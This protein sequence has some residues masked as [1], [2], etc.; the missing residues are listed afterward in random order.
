MQQ[1]PVIWEIYK[2][3][4]DICLVTQHLY[5]TLVHIEPVWTLLQ[6]MWSPLR[7]TSISA[8]AGILLHQVP[9]SVQK[10][11]HRPLLEALHHHHSNDTC[12]WPISTT[13][14]L[15]LSWRD[16]THESH[17]VQGPDCTGDKPVSSNA[18]SAACPE[19]CRPQGGRHC[20]A[21]VPD[22]MCK[23]GCSLDGSKNVS[24]GFFSSGEH[25]WW[26]Q[27][28]TDFF[29]WICQSCSEVMGPAAVQ[30]VSC[31]SE[32]LAGMSMGC[33]PLKGHDDYF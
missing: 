25:W 15:V 9:D 28:A 12:V 14:I 19:H 27:R 20:H 8:A 3:I 13:A 2:Y 31:N 26:C 18:Q 30:K 4:Q 7:I 24:R 1:Q 16:W 22:L 11:L 21:T 29:V 5:N 33:L 6:V 10:G 32:T 17:T 23:L